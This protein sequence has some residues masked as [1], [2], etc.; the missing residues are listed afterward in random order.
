MQN[1]DAIE[2]AILAL[3]LAAEI[4]DFVQHPDKFFPKDLV[5]VCFEQDRD[6][7]KEL[8]CTTKH[9]ASSIEKTE[10]LEKSINALSVNAL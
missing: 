9:P 4:I 2:R 10:K 6:R 5:R 3:D 8:L 1:S 7:L